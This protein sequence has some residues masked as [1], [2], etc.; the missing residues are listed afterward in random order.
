[1]VQESLAQVGPR[2]ELTARRREARYVGRRTAAQ[3]RQSQRIGATITVDRVQIQRPQ[4]YRLI[5]DAN[6][7]SVVAHDAAGA[8]YAAQTLKQICRPF[9]TLLRRAGKDQEHRNWSVLT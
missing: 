5:I 8:F 2:W 4:G 1:M 7:I 3:R 9:V 6:Q